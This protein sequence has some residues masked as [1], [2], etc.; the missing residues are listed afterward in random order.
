M[1]RIVV[2]NDIHSNYFLLS[3]IFNELNNIN[4][5]EY[6][7]CGDSI[8]DGFDNN[9]VLDILR[10]KNSHIIAGNRER[11]ITTT[12]PS[13]WEGLNQWNSMF[14][15][16]N[17]LTE[18]NK[19]FITSLPTYQIISVEGKKICMSHGSPYHVREEVDS[20]STLLFDKLIADFDCDIYLFAHTH[21]PFYKIYK[22]KFFIN[23]GAVSCLADGHPASTYGI[24]K[25]DNG[26]IN[27]E[28]REY[29]YDFEEVKNYYLNN[30]YSSLCQ[31][32][33]NLILA[34]LLTGID[35]CCNFIDYLNHFTTN[36]EKHTSDIWNESF[37]SF[38]KLNDLVV[39]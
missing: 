1:K 26:T 20:N 10:E 36:D 7:V 37:I 3:K 8:T 30:E 4:I 24:I 19:K 12:S 33:C 27:Y 5:D 25:I 34:T 38:M 21:K 9:K 11:T 32:W 14:Y 22:N 15:A 39:F 28:Q 29:C 17:S 35:Y 2:L 23:S 18:E 13:I 31:E 6:I 16:Y